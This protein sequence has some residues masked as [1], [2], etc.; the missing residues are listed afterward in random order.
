MTTITPTQ[1]YVLVH[2]GGD[3]AGHLA[4]WNDL[5]MV[6]FG[7]EP[8]AAIFENEVAPTLINSYSPDKF[9][10]MTLAAFFAVT[11]SM[12]EQAKRFKRGD[13]NARKRIAALEDAITTFLEEGIAGSLDPDEF[14]AETEALAEAVGFEFT[15]QRTF[16]IEVV[17]TA[18]VKR[19]YTVE[20]NDFDVDIASNV[21]EI[22]DIEL[23]S[24]YLN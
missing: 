3:L 20:A 1:Q 12:V 14:M 21:D 15:E 16:T 13:E 8:G 17:F 2:K 4:T 11:A 5:Q 7:Q 23:E 10:L 22:E 24:Q 9:D 6:E 19:G 18:N